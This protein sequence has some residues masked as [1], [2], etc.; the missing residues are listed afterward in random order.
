MA[1]LIYN[2][3]VG[4]VRETEGRYQPS[5]AINRNRKMNTKCLKN[6]AKGSVY[7]NAFVHCGFIGRLKERRAHPPRG[8]AHG[9]RTSLP[10]M[11][12]TT[13]TEMRNVLSFM[14][15]N[16][17]G[18]EVNGF[19]F[20]LLAPPPPAKPTRNT[21]SAVKSCNEGVGDSNS[22]TCNNLLSLF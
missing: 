21:T 16:G 1:P 19:G 9:H 15:L 6:V 12:G 20:A 5:F 10:E 7:H 4:G 11:V 18:F 13:S 3:C 14:E 22:G 2:V 8:W 17:E